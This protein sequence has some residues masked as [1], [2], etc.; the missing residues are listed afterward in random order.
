MGRV[1]IGAGAHREIA[2]GDDWGELGDG[3]CGVELGEI[4]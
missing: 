3:L 1:V 4:R 2:E